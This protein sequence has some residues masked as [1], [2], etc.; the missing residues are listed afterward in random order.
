MREKLRIDFRKA[1]YELVHT[2][3]HGHEVYRNG[4]SIAVLPP[5][6]SQQCRIETARRRAGL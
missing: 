5:S 6:G 2:T 3:A 1:G 4:K